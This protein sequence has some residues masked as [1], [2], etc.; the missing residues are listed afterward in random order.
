METDTK[1]K[2]IEIL[3]LNPNELDYLKF[4]NIPNDIIYDKENLEL[5]KQY[6]NNIISDK[7]KMKRLD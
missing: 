5:L 3:N 7:N 1:I 4:F 6:F 2:I